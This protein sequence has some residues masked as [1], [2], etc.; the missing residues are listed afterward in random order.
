MTSNPS[1]RSNELRLAAILSA[2]GIVLLVSGSRFHG[3]TQPQDL[4]AVCADYAANPY[5]HLVHLLQFLGLF[6]MLAGQMSLL[7]LI[8]ERSD[9]SFAWVATFAAVVAACTYAANQAVDGAAIQ[10][11]SQAFVAAP[12]PERVTALRIAEAVRHVE[13]GLSGLAVFS[14]GLAL[15][16]AGAAILLSRVFPLWLGW[17]ALLPGA[18]QLASGIS[19]YFVGFEHHRL[20]VLA[21]LLCLLWTAAAAISMWREARAQSLVVR[22]SPKSDRR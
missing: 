13:Q 22:L 1:N 7:S 20:G 14:W 15:L 8:R 2:V 4:K 18:A 12:E 5:W 10:Y 9:S 17:G 3:G 19:I 21:S 11:V 16:L 6:A